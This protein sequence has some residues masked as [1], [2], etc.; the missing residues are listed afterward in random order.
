MAELEK[1]EFEFPDEIEAKKTKDFKEEPEIEIVDDTPEQ[2]RNRTPMQTPPQEPTDE[3]LAAYSQKDRNKL[4][5]FTKGYH[6]ERR[7]KESAIRE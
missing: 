7:A 6:D 5:E 3:E 4:R 1:T 2:D